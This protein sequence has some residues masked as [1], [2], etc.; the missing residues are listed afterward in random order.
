MPRSFLA[1]VL[2]IALLVSPGSDAGAETATIRGVSRIYLRTGPGTSHE[3]NGVVVEGEPISTIERIGSWV[4]VETA[5]GRVG[6]VY[7]G[8]LVVEEGAGSPP[9]ASA[10]DAP[11]AG[12]PSAAAASAAP[13]T[14]PGTP[15]EMMPLTDPAGGVAALPAAPEGDGLREEIATLKAEVE[16]LKSEVASGSSG[17]R[18]GT[19]S[20]PAVS[21][22]GE[23]AS[24]ATRRPATTGETDEGVN[25]RTAGVALFSLVIGWI[26]G[27][28]FS[29]RRSRSSR[30]RLRF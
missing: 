17:I 4:K 29:R 28:G 22:A 14:P 5:D 7:S 27:A 2:L 9:A 24:T 6:Y 20:L 23:S 16:R 11:Q 30:G 25:L 19:A 26:L 18:G 12:D 1:A 21:A 8:Y 3:P 13:E 10:D 15:V